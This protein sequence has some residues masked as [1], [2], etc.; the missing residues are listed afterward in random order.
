MG[1]EQVVEDGIIIEANEIEIGL[2]GGSVDPISS[3]HDGPL[4]SVYFR[5]NGTNF[6]KTGASLF[7]WILN[8]GTGDIGLA[9]KFD[10]S[11]SVLGNYTLSDKVTILVDTTSAAITIT[12]PLA[13]TFINKFFNIKWLA[14][15][16]N[17]KVTI[18]GSSGELLDDSNTHNMGRIFD[19][20]SVMSIGTGWIIF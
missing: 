6:T 18:T 17:N 12:L 13:A 19:C 4:G 20:L 7:D 16:P 3:G 10:A 8:G 15:V 1:K 9:N 11:I 5:Q 14:G 2:Y